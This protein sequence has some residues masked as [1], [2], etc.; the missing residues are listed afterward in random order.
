M[1]RRPPGTTL[2]RVRRRCALLPLRGRRTWSDAQDKHSL[3]ERIIPRRSRSIGSASETSNVEKG[4]ALRCSV[5]HAEYAGGA[6]AGE[7]M[8]ALRC[9]CLQPRP[10][11]IAEQCRGLPT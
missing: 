1:Y 5:S 9:C 8:A 7:T 3:R 11:S 2:E 10:I 6:G 4:E